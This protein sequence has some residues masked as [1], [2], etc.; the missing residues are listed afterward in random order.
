MTTTDIYQQLTEAFPPEMERNLSKGGTNLTYIPVS[1]VINRLNKTL[2]V[3]QWSFTVEMCERDAIDT[4]FVIARVRLV[5]NTVPESEGAYARRVVRD[6][7]G[8]Q[9]INRTKAGAIVDL[10]NDYK[11]AVSDALKKAAQTLGVALYLARSDDA[12]EIE[13]AMDAPA[14][15]DE[16]IEAFN[17]IVALSKT[18]NKEQ[19][20]EM[21]SKWLEIAGDLPKPRKATD[22]PVE[23]LKALHDEA[24]RLSFHGTLIT[25]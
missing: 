12:I 23:M 5:W 14:V 15:S 16:A 21:N 2:G 18:F 11:G 20:D 9:K 3:D 22:A 19:K 13:L 25:K 24:V 6:G 7:I 1:E 8:G 10:G 4:D 17:T